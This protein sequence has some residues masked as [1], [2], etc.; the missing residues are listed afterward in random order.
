MEKKKQEPKKKQTFVNSTYS[1][2]LSL[3]LPLSLFSLR[4]SVIAH[5]VERG[6]R[7]LLVLVLVLMLLRRECVSAPA[8]SSVMGETECVQAALLPVY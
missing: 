6:D 5:S 8:Y 1:I 3:F 7:L 2:I 4:V